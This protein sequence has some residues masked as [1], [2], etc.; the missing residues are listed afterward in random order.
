[1]CLVKFILRRIYLI[2]AVDPYIICPLFVPRSGAIALW[3]LYSLFHPL[4]PEILP[5]VDSCPVDAT[6]ICGV[7]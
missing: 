6:Q 4:A 2:L 3:S 7:R 5:F 1:M